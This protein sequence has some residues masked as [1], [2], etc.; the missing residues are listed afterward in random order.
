MI[1]KIKAAFLFIVLMFAV[2][3]LNA[4]ISATAYVD[5]NNISIDDTLRLTI[6]INGNLRN[7]SGLNLSKLA[8]FDIISQSQEQS[9][10][11]VN[12]SFSLSYKKIYTLMPQKIGKITI[13]AFAITIKG[14]KYETKPITIEVTKSNAQIKNPGKGGASAASQKTLKSL[15][16]DVKVSKKKVYLGEPV[17]VEFT[18]YR[19][20]QKWNLSFAPPSFDGFYS[21]LVKKSGEHYTNISGVRYIANSF[22]YVLVPITSGKKDIGRGQF[23][24]V[25]DPF[26]G[27]RRVS[28]DPFSIKVLP[29]PSTNKT[30]FSGSVGRLNIKASVNKNR[31]SDTETLQLSIKISGNASL[32]FINAPNVDFTRNFRVFDK[33]QN[34]NEQYANGQ[35]NSVKEFNYMLIPKHLGKIIIPPVAYT[36]FDFAAKRYITKKTAP[37]TVWISG[38]GHSRSQE[39]SPVVSNKTSNSNI[40]YIFIDIPKKRKIPFKNIV[41]GEL[42]LFLLVNAIVLIIRFNVPAMFRKTD[43]RAETLKAVIR[44]RSEKEKDVFIQKLEKTLKNYISERYGLKTLDESSLKRS[45]LEAFSSF[46]K[47]IN[48]IRYSPESKT[49]DKARILRSAEEL[50]K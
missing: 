26:S 37:I 2:S 21:R 35:I 4:A 38:R 14:K 29:L 33:R 5:K 34:E 8:N 36:Y 6:E 46:F 7:I 12:G 31:I 23:N 19:R 20:I 13:P 24:F 1:G 47:E 42:I 44:L 45:G 48:D 28:T 17:E 22:K 18:Y 49:F 43:V 40:A 41:Y 3:S 50:L 27:P 16:A 11:M 25:I 32:K 39:I 9:F 30:D 15:M 10:S